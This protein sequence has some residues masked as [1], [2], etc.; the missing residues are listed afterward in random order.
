MTLSTQAEG[1]KRGDTDDDDGTE[2]NGGD[3]DDGE[4]DC[5]WQQCVSGAKAFLECPLSAISAPLPNCL[6]AITCWEAYHPMCT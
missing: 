1:D 3:D 6:R 2:D 5:V 4:E